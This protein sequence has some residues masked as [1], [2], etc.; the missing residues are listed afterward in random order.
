MRAGVMNIMIVM[1]IDLA[2][3]WLK[4]NNGGERKCTVNENEIT[5]ENPYFHNLKNS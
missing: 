5:T 1:E 4:E 2:V 3:R